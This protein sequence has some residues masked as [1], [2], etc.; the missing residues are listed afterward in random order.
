M[1]SSCHQ[2]GG[3]W[4]AEDFGETRRNGAGPLVGRRGRWWGLWSQ[5][6][7]Q[8]SVARDFSMRR[9]TFVVHLQYHSGWLQYKW[10]IRTTICLW[11]SGVHSVI[12]WDSSYRSLHRYHIDVCVD[13]RSGIHPVYDLWL[14]SYRYMGYFRANI[15]VLYVTNWSAVLTH[16]VYILVYILDSTY[17]IVYTSW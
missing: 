17:S 16:R 10:W 8:R 13:A 6:C 7:V 12:Q 2:N 14:V 4:K 15:G 5:N 3:G 1:T 11:L 9:C